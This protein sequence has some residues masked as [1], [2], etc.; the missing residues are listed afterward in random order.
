[1]SKHDFDDLMRH[2]PQSQGGTG[3]EPGTAFAASSAGIRMEGNFAQGVPVGYDVSGTKDM[4]MQSNVACGCDVALVADDTEDLGVFDF[5]V[6]GKRLEDFIGD[7]EDLTVWSADDIYCVGRMVKDTDPNLR[8]S[9]LK[10]SEFGNWL[11][12]RDFKDWI[13]LCNFLISLEKFLE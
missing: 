13:G 7:F 2:V 11:K 12:K 6:D 3:P 10:N 9:V 4:T 1:M 8:I 5:E